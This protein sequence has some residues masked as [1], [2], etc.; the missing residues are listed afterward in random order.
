M[1]TVQ[2]SE[3]AAGEELE[4]AKDAKLDEEGKQVG[5]GRHT[6]VGPRGSP[7]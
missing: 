1:F 7:P 3:Q 5:P 2:S 6:P 4:D